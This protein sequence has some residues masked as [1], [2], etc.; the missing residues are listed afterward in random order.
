MLWLRLEDGARKGP[1]LHG[2]IDE[3]GRFTMPFVLP[4][5]YSLTVNLSKK[6]TDAGLQAPPPVEVTVS[7]GKETRVDVTV[8]SK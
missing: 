4:G 6:G 7:E 5:R 2:T 8:Q 3:Q 1:P